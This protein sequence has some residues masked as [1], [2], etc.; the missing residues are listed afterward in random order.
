MGDIYINA[1]LSES[2]IEDKI[3]YLQD[4][5][6]LFESNLGDDIGNAYD[7]IDENT[8]HAKINKAIYSNQSDQNLYPRYK[9]FVSIA[10]NVSSYEVGTAVTIIGLKNNL[11]NAA[12]VDYGSGLIGIP[13]TG[14]YF[15]PSET[16]VIR[17]TTNYDGIYNIADGGVLNPNFI[18][19]NAD[20]VAETFAGTE[21][22]QSGID[23]DLMLD[24]IFVSSISAVGEYEL[25]L[26]RTEQWS[27][28]E[29]ARVPLVKTATFSSEGFIPL[30]SILL[31]A[32]GYY[33]DT[34]KILVA[35]V[36]SNAAADTVKIKLCY[37]L[38]AV[39]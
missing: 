9:P 4:Y 27:G 18:S 1:Q 28:Y 11:D 16:I 26:Y 24:G 22:M 23:N 13:V 36:S 20:Y 38:F 31:P 14:H 33:P 29:I 34:A 12:A 2:I 7:T 17:G 25:I 19:I 30:K 37:H 3:D 8:I 39:A 10:A 21:T 6:E 5:T 32:C 35:L 15:F